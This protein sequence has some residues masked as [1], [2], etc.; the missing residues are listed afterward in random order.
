MSEIESQLQHCR[1]GQQPDPLRLQLDDPL[2]RQLDHVQ[3]GHRHLLP[4]RVEIVVCGV[5]RHGQT[6]RTSVLQASC[7]PDQFVQRTR[8]AFLKERRNP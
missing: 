4:Q 2:G 6:M 1:R 8:S 5:A 7:H 3:E